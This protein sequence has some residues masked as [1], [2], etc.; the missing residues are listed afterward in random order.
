MPGTLV[1]FLGDSGAFPRL[2]SFQIQFLF[3]LENSRRYVS[4]LAANKSNNSK[5]LMSFIVKI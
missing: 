5:D 1:V 3:S 4:S 2:S